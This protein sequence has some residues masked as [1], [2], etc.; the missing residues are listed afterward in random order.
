MKELCKLKRNDIRIDFKKI[1][2]IVRK[3]KFVCDKCARVAAKKTFLCS[4]S[5]I[6]KKV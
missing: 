4:P 3:P 1:I 6:K 5:K 2:N